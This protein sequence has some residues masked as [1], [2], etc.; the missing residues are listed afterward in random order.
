ML[1]VLGKGLRLNFVG[2]APVAYEEKNNRSFELNK[3]FGI[4]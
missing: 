3:D 1:Q 4:G 2:K